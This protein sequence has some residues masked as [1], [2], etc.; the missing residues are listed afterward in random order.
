MKRYERLFSPVK[1]G[2]LTLKNRIV[3]APQSSEYW[4]EGQMITP[5]VV[6]LYEG[7]A[8]GGASMILVGA[9]LFQPAEPE[10]PFLFGGLSADKHI[11]GMTEL[12]SAVHKHDCY[13]LAQLHHPGPAPISATYTPLAS[14]TLS[15]DQVPLDYCAP[16]HGV[17]LD[18]IEAMKADYIEA[19]V[20]AQKAGF[21]GVECHSANGYFLL[22]FLSRA[23]N[24]RTDQYGPQNMENRTRLHRELIAGIRERCGAD[25]V[26]GVRINGQEFGHPNAITPAEGAEAAALLEAAGAQYISVTGY[27]YGKTPMQYV[28]DYW[29]YPEPD[30]FMKPYVKRFKTGLLVPAAEAVKKAVNIPVITV[31]RLDEELGEEILKAGRADLILFGRPLWADHDLPDK[32]EHGKRE[33]IVRCCRCAT[34]EDP[35]DGPRRCRVNPA[36]G[37]EKELAI[38][39]APEKKRVMVV[40]AGPAGM[41]AARVA[42]MRGHE[43]TLFEKSGH[44]GG[45]LHLAT[46]IKGTDFDDVSTIIEY[47]SNQVRHLPIAVKTG[48][49]VDSRLILETKPDVVILALGGVY[50][51]PDTV[52]GILGSNVSGVTSLAEM[53]ERPLRLLG[54]SAV[55]KLSNIAL[56]GVGKNVVILGGQIEGLQGAVFLRK[57]GRNVTVLEEG[58]SLGGRMPPRYFK[59]TMPW[60]AKEG[61]QV[62][63]GVHYDEVTKDGLLATLSDGRQQLFAADTV[64]ALLPPNPNERLKNS[65]SGIASEVYSVGCGNG[66][67]SSLI[68]DA[69]TEAREL[70]C[71]I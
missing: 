60:L 24:Y 64:L 42:S 65:I 54:A 43:V 10:L 2:H 34:C 6:D 23:W 26:I 53:A 18:E 63:T 39:P 69:L 36:L 66:V 45:K 41:E 12:A 28:A 15:A 5:R 27:G 50:A 67:D 38:V 13:V 9:I 61:V 7:I 44:L 59:R 8:Q 4:L 17:T 70:G 48:V 21:D 68:I 33:D 71:R 57:R 31:G 47:L 35:Q 58:D 40:G 30:D 52:P 49:E 14:T 32:L 25:F 16:T 37:R 20:R 22:S 56:P 55:S 3:K 51:V 29:P 62:L 19:A 1:V 11:P 46:M